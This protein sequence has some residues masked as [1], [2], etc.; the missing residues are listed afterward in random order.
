VSSAL[1]QALTVGMEREDGHERPTSWC[2]VKNCVVCVHVAQCGDGLCK[3]E[4]CGSQS[5]G[6]ADA[7]DGAVCVCVCVCPLK[8]E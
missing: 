7:S 8:E 1:T 3:C 6:G 4:V 5:G 2:A